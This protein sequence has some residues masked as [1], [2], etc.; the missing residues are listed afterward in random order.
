MPQKIN[1]SSPPA[2]TLKKETGGG[3]LCELSKARGSTGA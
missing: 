1:G 2:G 3:Y